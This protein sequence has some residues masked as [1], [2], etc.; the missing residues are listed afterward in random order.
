MTNVNIKL[1]NSLCSSTF[2]EISKDLK[3]SVIQNEIRT[4]LAK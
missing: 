3:A 1:L 2:T 4:K